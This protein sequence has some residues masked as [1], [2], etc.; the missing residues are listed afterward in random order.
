[1]NKFFFLFYKHFLVQTYLNRIEKWLNR[2]RMTMAPH[3]CNYIVFSNNKTQ[4]ID[5]EISI[6]L[7]GCNISENVKPTF[8]GIRFD[9]HLTFINQLDYLKVYE[10]N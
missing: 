10:K 4:K 1:M 2:W 7:F 5:D 8:L 3:K 9:K 6:E